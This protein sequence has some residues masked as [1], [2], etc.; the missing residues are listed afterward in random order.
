MRD[1]ILA[2]GFT[3]LFVASICVMGLLWAIYKVLAAIL[4]KLRNI[5]ASEEK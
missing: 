2:L 3:A 5:T 4:D 1:Q